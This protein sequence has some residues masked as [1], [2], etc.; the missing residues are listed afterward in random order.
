M[1]VC[2]PMWMRSTS[3]LRMALYQILAPALIVT[4]PMMVLLGATK[5]AR[6]RSTAGQNEGMGELGEFSFNI[7]ADF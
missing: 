1:F 4:S 6:D 5:A 3:P 7:E 2:S